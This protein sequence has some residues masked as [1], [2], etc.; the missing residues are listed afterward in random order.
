MNHPTSKVLQCFVNQTRPGNVTTVSKANNKRV[1]CLS[2]LQNVT[3][4]APLKVKGVNE[5][6][7][8]ISV[9]SVCSEICKVV[10]NY[11]PLFAMQNNNWNT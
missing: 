6:Q 4:V 1:I 3:T 8:L 11:A 5:K 9:S 2:M 7:I 10:T